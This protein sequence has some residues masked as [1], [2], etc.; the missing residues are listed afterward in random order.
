MFSQ[1]HMVPQEVATSHRMR[2]AASRDLN[3]V[4]KRQFQEIVW[5]I[6]ETS[7]CLY[8]AALF[9]LVFWC[10]AFSEKESQMSAVVLKR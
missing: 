6:Y 7:K 9:H 10:T 4:P 2:L 8:R 5:Q 1:Y 3:H